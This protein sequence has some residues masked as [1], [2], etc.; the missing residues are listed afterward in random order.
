MSVTNFWDSGKVKSIWE[1][2]PIFLPDFI[3]TKNCNQ[4]NQEFIEFNLTFNRK[5]RIVSSA[6]FQ[7]CLFC[8]VVSV[9]II[10]CSLQFHTCYSSILLSSIVPKQSCNQ[11]QIHIFENS[12]VISHSGQVRPADAI[13]I[14]MIYTLFLQCL[15]V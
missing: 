12:V 2:K 1:Y 8:K 7:I 4:I 15:W 14:N 10:K 5:N 11:F 13:D 9:K 3:F 6:C